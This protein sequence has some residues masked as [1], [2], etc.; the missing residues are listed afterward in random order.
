MTIIF[1]PMYIHILG[2]ESYGVIGFYASLMVAL[3]LLDFG[4]GQTLTREAAR[5][6]VSRDHRNDFF[7]LIGSLEY[8]YGAIAIVAALVFW[9]TSSQISGGWL[10]TETISSDT[11]ASVI[12]IMGVVAALQWT[13]GIYRSVLIG[14]QEQVWLNIFE[15]TIA[16]LRGVGVIGVLLYLSPTLQGFFLYQLSLV[17]VEVVILRGKVWSL[18][19]LSCLCFPRFYLHQVLR[20]WRFAGSVTVISVMGTLVSQM[21]KLILPGIISLRAY[22]YYMVASV[23]A[24]SS[25]LSSCYCLS[26]SFC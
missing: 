8:V 18:N 19:N 12:S 13:G 10:Q 20:I 14:L 25:G 22:G 16:T 5:S 23:L 24:K 4:I 15:M 2:I 17:V 21:D 7:S 1:I 11:L 6:S 26:T 9:I 3:S